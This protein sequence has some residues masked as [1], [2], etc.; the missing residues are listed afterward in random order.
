MKIRIVGMHYAPEPSGN[1]P[2]T[3][4]LAEGLASRGHEVSVVTGVPHYPE[5]RVYPGYAKWASR[6][7]TGGV[8]LVRLRHYVP[9]SPTLIRRVIMETSFGVRAAARRV[10]RD[11]D[12]VLL[13]S[14]A[15]L[16][17]ATVL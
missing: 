16:S 14:P 6:Q 1:A 13:V 7:T 12:V 15:L 11:A 17:T 10:L 5:W 2:Y 8:D 3:T 4:G 9:K